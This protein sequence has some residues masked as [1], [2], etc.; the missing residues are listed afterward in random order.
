MAEF[1]YNSSINRTKSLSPFDIVT[2]FR[3]RQLIDLVLITHHHS[4]ASDSASTF[5]S[6]IRTLNVEIRKKDNEK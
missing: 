6:H 5:A 3:P 1:A 2:D 4:R